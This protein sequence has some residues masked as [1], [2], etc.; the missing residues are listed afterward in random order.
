MEQASQLQKE[1][2]QQLQIIS[3]ESS[4]RFSADKQVAKNKKVYI[5]TNFEIP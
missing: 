3:Y 4:E 1:Q 2:Q 5:D